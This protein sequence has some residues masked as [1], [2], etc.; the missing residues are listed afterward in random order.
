MMFNRRDFCTGVVGGMLAN[1]TGDEGLIFSPD[2]KKLSVTSSGGKV[3][4]T[5][6]DRFADVINPK[7]FGALGNGISDDT[8][9]L[10]DALDA[11]AYAASI[12]SP[13]PVYAPGIY[14]I[15]SP[16]VVWGAANQEIHICAII[17]DNSSWTGGSW[18]ESKSIYKAGTWNGSGRQKSINWITKPYH[19]SNVKNAVPPAVWVRAQRCDLYFSSIDCNESC[20]GI[21]IDTTG[22]VLQNGTFITHFK[23][24]GITWPP[25]TNCVLF[26]PNVQQYDLGDSNYAFRDAPG[27]LIQGWDSKVIGGHIGRCNPFK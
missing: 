3:A 14:K 8:V 15:S 26:N 25:K 4:R 16:L 2:V 23:A 17:V 13:I 22:V 27:L 5:M 1:K 7:D 19:T 6:A 10:Q 20:P 18:I 11:S 9:P 24:Y 12:G 21:Y